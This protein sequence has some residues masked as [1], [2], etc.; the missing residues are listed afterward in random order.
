MGS[1]SW[2]TGFIFMAIAASVLS[3]QRYFQRKNQARML[4]SLRSHEWWAQIVGSKVQLARLYEFADDSCQI[5]DHESNAY[6][7][8]SRVRAEN[9]MQEE[10]YSR[11]AS[12][13]EAGELPQDFTVPGDGDPSSDTDDELLLA[14]MQ[15][16]P[17][18][19]PFLDRA[20]FD[21][22]GPEREDVRCA[23]LGCAYGA[24]ELSRLCRRHHFENVMGRPF[25]GL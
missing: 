13:I 2:I 16:S 21:S 24:V 4:R 1:S 20:F 5:V 11:V 3:I 8:E 25:I 7:F 22:L 10:E 6:S 9:W 12:L 14:R 19:Q 17:D 18:I 15:E 23:H